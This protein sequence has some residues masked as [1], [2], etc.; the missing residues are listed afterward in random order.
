MKVYTFK[1]SYNGKVLESGEITANSLRS[2][3]SKVS[4]ICKVKGAWYV[5]TG[6]TYW[7]KTQL[8]GYVAKPRIEMREKP[9]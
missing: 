3:K 2:A 8:S 4:S 7:V 9:E 6:R 1:T 5:P